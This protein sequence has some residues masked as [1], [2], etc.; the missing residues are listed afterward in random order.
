MEV[1]KENNLLLIESNRRKLSLLTSPATSV[2]PI[3][4][5]PFSQLLIM[6][7]QSRWAGF[8]SN[9]SEEQDVP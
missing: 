5:V 3:P 9:Q 8:T 1:L 4:P 7:S 6:R 2:F